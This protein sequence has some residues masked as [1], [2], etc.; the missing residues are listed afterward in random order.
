MS[1]LSAG[2][3]SALRRAVRLL[4]L[5]RRR[6]LLAVL[7]GSLGL[8]SSVGLTATSAWL[9]ARASQMPAVLD[10]TVA[11]VGVRTFGIS[12]SVLRYFER[13]VSHDV[14]LRG[15]ASL[16]EQVYRRLADSPVEAVAGLRRGDLLVR[17]GADVDAVGD[18]VVRALLPAGVAVVVGTGT[19]GLVAW[20]SPFSG[21]LLALCLL[22]AGTVG[23]YLNARAARAS[24]LAQGDARSAL[25]ATALTM[26]DGGAELA[27]WGRLDAV[28]GQLRDHE[29][30]IA[31]LQDRAAHPAALAGGIDIGAMGLSVLG[32]ILVGVPALT[33]GA[34]A[35]VE[36]AVIV[37]TPLAAFEATSTL[38]QAAVQLVR[39]AGA[40]ERIMGLL[41]AARGG[42]ERTVEVPA[43]VPSELCAR[44][45]DIGWPDGPVV[46][47][48]V[49]LTV[50]PGRA[51]AVAGPS[52]IGK[53][54]LL[55]TLA[56]LLPPRAGAV[57]LGGIDVA[58]AT[59]AS[60]T[61]HVTMTAEDA[62]IFATTVL[63]NLRVARGDVTE[64]EARE[65]LRRCG[66]GG[67]LAGLPEGL[68]TLLGA[69]GANVSGGERR[70]LLLARALASPAPLILVDEPAEHLDRATADALM[71]E[72]ISL[73]H[74]DPTRGV[75]VVTHHLGA[76]G[77]ADEV[78]L[79][80]S[81]DDGVA[82]VCDRGTHAELAARNAGYRSAA[83]EVL[84]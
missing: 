19:V 29:A 45:V 16:R 35:P 20:L 65:L 54:T 68:D 66:L 49:D 43:D 5:D 79:L 77:G 69:D 41:D 83:S 63:E 38:G 61:A 40:A 60:V 51:V 32:A 2:Q 39:S 84:T 44:R 76:L 53:T 30:R 6:V 70:R 23:P 8:G 17:T 31:H 33:S 81:G 28:R 72:L 11:S 74:R 62:H 15:M 57:E 47:R 25:A 14:A 78:V 10:L 67:W 22:L 21:L 64:A 42:A 7:A 34:L 26:V 24:E 9:I 52:G 12:R 18:V 50:A 80:D 75:V 1:V 56:G 4:D 55:S 73:P 82:V 37:L 27:V 48:G 3:R 71:A 58:R 46:A 13:L 59:R 36:L